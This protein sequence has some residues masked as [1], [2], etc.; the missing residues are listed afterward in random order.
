MIGLG[1]LQQCFLG[2]DVVLC[3]LDG[4]RHG[5]ALRDS[6]PHCLGV[7]ITGGAAHTRDQGIVV[8]VRIQLVAP[9]ADLVLGVGDPGKGL[10]EP[11]ILDQS[12]VIQLIRHRGHRVLRRDLHGHSFRRSPVKGAQI[13]HQQPAHTRQD[14]GG[15][16]YK[17]N[18]DDRIDPSAAPPA[19]CGLRTVL[20]AAP[21]LFRVPAGGISSFKIR[22][23]NLRFPRPDIVG[24]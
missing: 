1:S 18:I 23:G 20:L 12:G 24:R 10:E 9:H 21:H 15:G 7:H 11:L 6:D 13:A 5:I 2:A 16:Y 3:Q 8:H 4:L 19:A 14:S 22:H 17:Q